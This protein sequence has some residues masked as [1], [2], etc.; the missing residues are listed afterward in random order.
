MDKHYTGITLKDTF[1][2]RSIMPVNWVMPGCTRTEAQRQQLI[3]SI[4]CDILSTNRL[5]TSR[6]IMV[7]NLL[8][9]LKGQPLS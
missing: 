7:L 3:F 5:R 4:D 9:T 2:P 8:T 6:P 1:S